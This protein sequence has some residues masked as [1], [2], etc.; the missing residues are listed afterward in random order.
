M[1]ASEDGSSMPKW[2]KSSAGLVETFSAAVKPLQ[3][4]EQRKMFGYP[5]AFF[6]GHMFAGLHQ[7]NM[8]L[9]LDPPDRAE[10]LS[11]PGA[12]AFEPMAGRPMREY[13]VVPPEIV[14]S[15]SALAPWL[16]KAVSYAGALPEKTASRKTK[17]K[18]KSGPAKA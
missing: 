13:V 2:S 5:C 14:A 3:G 18:P 9:R 11:L 8:I 16:E 7:E 12:R 1:M 6:N 17:P 4:A 15:P 10:F